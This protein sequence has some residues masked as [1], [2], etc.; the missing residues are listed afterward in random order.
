MK[1]AVIQNEGKVVK[2]GEFKHLMALSLNPKTDYSEGVIRCITQRIGDVSIKGFL[3][4]SVLY[5]VKAE[6][7]FEHYSVTKPL[8]IAGYE[9]IIEKLSIDELEFIGLEDPDLILDSET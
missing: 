6:K 5:K 8:G 7:K 1:K 3:D 9:K 2:S 4:R